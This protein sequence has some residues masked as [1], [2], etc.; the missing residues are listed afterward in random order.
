MHFWQIQH[1]FIC[2]EDLCKL[3]KEYLNTLTCKFYTFF[4]DKI[5][6]LLTWHTP[7]TR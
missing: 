2:S 7:F 1:N 6:K 4:L 3:S 5:S